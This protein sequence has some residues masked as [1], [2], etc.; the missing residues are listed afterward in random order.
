LTL[1]VTISKTLRLGLVIFDGST[2]SL[3][4]H[5]PPHHTHA[6]HTPALEMQQQ[7]ALHHLQHSLI[8]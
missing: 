2:G 7:M 5:P 3:T 1:L 8:E 4:E 6:L